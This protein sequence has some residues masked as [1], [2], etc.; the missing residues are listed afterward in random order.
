MKIELIAVGRLRSGP[1]YELFK[2]Y[3][4]RLTWPFSLI[5]IASKH[6]DPQAAQA[7]EHQQIQKHLDPSAFIVALDERG[8][9]LSSGAFAE[10]LQKLQNDGRP[11]IQFIIGGADGLSDDLR[12]R[13]NLLLSFGVQTWPHRLVRVMVL[14]QIYRAQQI[15]KGH[16]Y[17][18]D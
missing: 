8:K 10:T 9:P 14:E 12:K 15:L 11:K 3:D 7:D 2:T 18:R 6:K 5:E 16:P 17:H 1:E 4:K 13:A